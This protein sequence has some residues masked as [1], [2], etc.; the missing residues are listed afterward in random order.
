MPLSKQ[1]ALKR[2]DELIALVEEIR[3]TV[4]INDMYD[5][6]YYKAVYGSEDLVISLFGEKERDDFRQKMWNYTPGK[7]DT[8]VRSLGKCLVQLQLYKSRIGSQGQS[9]PAKEDTIA[10]L[11]R[12]ARRL[13][14]IADPLRHRRE[15]KL[16]LTLDDEYD[17]QYLLHALLFAFFDDV[18]AEVVTP[19]YAG[20]S[21]RIDFVLGNEQIGV[22][23]KKTR[24][25]L[26]ERELGDQLAIDIIRYLN[27]P[28]CKT[29]V[30]IVYDPDRHIR[31]PK[32]VEKDL[33]KKINEMLVH[34]FIAQG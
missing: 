30:G 33:S 16:P 2:I 6:N 21:S 5:D 29:L 9:N 26:N 27:Y 22:E 1:E 20:G 3:S 18:S 34:V 19:P 23:V 17:V 15:P 10:I 11:E 13:P 4:T 12:L 25:G 28:E 24:P 7:L 14:Q 8:Y 31:N 32:R